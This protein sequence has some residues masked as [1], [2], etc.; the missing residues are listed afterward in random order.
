MDKFAN[1]EAFVSVV[2]SG[3]FSRAAERLG[4]AKSVVS[5]RV[6]LLE[7]Q[8]GVQLLQRTT[9][10]QS[11]TSPGRLF[12]PRA[13]RL[14]AELD[15]AEQSIVDAAAAL[16][17]GVKLAAPLSFGLHHLSAALTDFLDQHPGIELDL[18]LNDREV[19]LV[20]EG[21]DMAV[22]IGALR[23]STLLARRLGTVRFVTCASP[24]YLARH[25]VPHQPGDLAGHIGLH[26]ANV[27]LQKAWRFSDGGREP[28]VAIP[29]IRLRANNGDL[30]ATAALAGLGI[31]NTPTFIVSE[32]IAS[33]ELVP[34]LDEY[35][36]EPVGIHAVYPPGRL[37]P[38]RVLALA[39]FLASRFGDLP[40]WDRAI[41]ITG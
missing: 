7:T 24:D 2:E 38:R 10:K 39:D 41:G 25:G 19:N 5:R 31:V 21:F 12:Y 26:Y 34:L 4:I 35:R 28:V 37:L 30:L 15:E 23:D 6:G 17:G 11:L 22:R 20:E 13:A 18:D 3:S 16:R 9:R 29:G 1:I 33:G 40:D 8:L 32:K 27:P 36:R 14:L